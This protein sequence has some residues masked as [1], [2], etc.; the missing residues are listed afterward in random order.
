MF[1]VENDSTRGHQV[2]ILSPCP[3]CRRT[4]VT[5]AFG[6]WAECPMCNSRID[7]EVDPTAKT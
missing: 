7:V 5:R 6:R 2:V 3:T 4:A 1:A